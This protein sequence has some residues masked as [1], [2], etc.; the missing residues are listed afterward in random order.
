ML[1]VALGLF[2]LYHSISLNA[3]SLRYP[4]CYLYGCVLWWFT[5]THWSLCCCIHSISRKMPNRDCSIHAIRPVVGL[6]GTS[7]LEQ[8][9]VTTATHTI[10]VERRHGSVAWIWTCQP[11]LRQGLEGILGHSFSHKSYVDVKR[12]SQMFISLKKYVMCIKQM[13]RWN[14]RFYIVRLKSL[15]PYS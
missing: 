7:Q 12:C 8:T 1:V 9:S 3:C 15:M 13:K 14:A 10:S 2:G 11:G 6:R 4:G 5:G